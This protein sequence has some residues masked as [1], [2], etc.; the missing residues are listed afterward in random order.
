MDR[1]QNPRL[2]RPCGRQNDGRHHPL[3]SQLDEP[4]ARRNR[5]GRRGT[6]RPRG[7]APRHGRGRHRRPPHH[8]QTRRTRR[9]N[10]PASTRI[11][12]PNRVPTRRPR[13]HRKPVEGGLH[14]ITPL[15][16]KKPRYPTVTEASPG[17]SLTSTNPAPRPTSSSKNPFRVFESSEP[18]LLRVYVSRRRSLK[19]TN[20]S[21]G[22]V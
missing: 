12:G 17:T 21:F 2:Q 7:P 18:G 19:W 6:R 14:P 10:G 8:R 5:E 3:H 16:S 13:V 11:Q 20:R 15:N 22:P 9:R 1:G 4:E